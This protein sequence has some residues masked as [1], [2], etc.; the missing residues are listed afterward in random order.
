MGSIAFALPYTSET[1]AKGFEFIAQLTG[2]RADEHHHRHKVHGLK[3]MRVWRQREPIEVVIVYL[4]A[5]NIDAM[6]DSRRTSDHEFERWF[7]RELQGITG[8]HWAECE[9]DL[10]LDWH[11]EEGHRI[12]APAPA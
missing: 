12:K 4:E 6:L 5:D 7:D 11:H 2:Q 9:G 10:L 1:V 3:H 8:H